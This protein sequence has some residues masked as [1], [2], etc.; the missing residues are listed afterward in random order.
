MDRA[1]INGV[2]IAY[3]V[4]GSGEPVMLCHCGF[5]AQDF[6]PLFIEPSIV[7]QFTLINYHRRGYGESERSE[8]ALTME[9]REANR[10]RGRHAGQDD[11]F[12]RSPAS[13]AGCLE[14]FEDGI[15]KLT[16]PAGVERLVR[17]DRRIPRGQRRSLECRRGRRRV[18]RASGHR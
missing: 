2:E 12:D 8:G 5:V 16:P 15:L 13:V 4:R 11:E 17:D 9:Q 6:S 3:E 10:H 7:E 1:K 14:R 18:H